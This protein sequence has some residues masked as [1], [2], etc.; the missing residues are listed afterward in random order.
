M[1]PFDYEPGEDYW[2]GMDV[3]QM[4]QFNKD[5]KL[6]LTNK[7]MKGV[8]K[9][10]LLMQKRLTSQIDKSIVSKLEVERESIKNLIT[11]SFQQNYQSSTTSTGP[12]KMLGM[13][14]TTTLTAPAPKLEMGK[15]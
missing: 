13:K 12:A 8:T 4:K 10:T 3:Y 2:P 9:Q 11:G 6:A 14:R 5:K 15:I 1:L 7:T